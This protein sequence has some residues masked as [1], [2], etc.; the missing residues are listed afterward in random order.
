[1][2]WQSIESIKTYWKSMSIKKKVLNC[3]FTMY[4]NSFSRQICSP[5]LASC[6]NLIT[7]VTPSNQRS[8]DCRLV[9]LSK[10][11]VLLKKIR[12]AYVRC[13]PSEAN[14][15]QF[16]VWIQLINT[17]A[18]PLV[19]TSNETRPKEISGDVWRACGVPSCIFQLW[20]LVCFER[21]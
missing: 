4:L 17:K 13:V 11:K 12:W 3:I 15:A 1:M 14:A 19:A 2:R 20:T 8:G 6:C 7:P 5:S 9:K 16:L 10:K 18:R 21:G